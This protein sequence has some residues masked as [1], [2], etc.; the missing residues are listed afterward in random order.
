M[1]GRLMIAPI[2]RLCTLR[3]GI[4]LALCQIR[5]NAGSARPCLMT[6]PEGIEAPA[7]ELRE[8]LW[9]LR[10]TFELGGFTVHEAAIFCIAAVKLSCRGE[11]SASH[12]D[13]SMVL[14]IRL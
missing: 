4:P 8:R 6:I 1:G 7:I 13:C 5:C 2:A 11:R 10:L 14:R 9:G 3:P 12:A